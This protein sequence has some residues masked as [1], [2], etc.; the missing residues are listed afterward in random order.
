MTSLADADDVLRVELTRVFDATPEE[1]FAA[2]TQPA[3]IVQWWGPQGFATDKADV[4]L[5]PG[6]LFHIHMRAEDGSYQGIVSGQFLEI[7]APYRLVFEITKH[8]NGAPHLFD[9][10]KMP[11]TTVTIELQPQ[12]NG[13]TE[14]SLTQTGFTDQVT[15][16]AHFGG[17]SSSLEKLSGLSFDR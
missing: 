9:A 4:Y 12:D 17:W 15:T 10:T 6:G 8:C 5:R 2:F 11:P 16:D 1:I 14:L 7:E 3:Q 13:Q